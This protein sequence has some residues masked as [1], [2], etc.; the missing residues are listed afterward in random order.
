[1]AM[2]RIGVRRMTMS[3]VGELAG[4]S[5]GT[6][7]RYFPTKEDLLGVVAQYEQQRFADGLRNAVEGAAGGGMQLEEVAEFIVSY[8]R[9]HPAVA[10]LVETEPA[11]SITF[12]RR[13]LPLFLAQTEELIGPALSNAVAVKEGRLTVPQLSEVLLRLVVSVFLVGG[14]TRSDT[15]GVLERVLSNFV[16]LVSASLD[17]I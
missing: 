10:M 3:D 13:E 9:E 2:G 7:Y 14:E 15:L 4:L 16:K 11:F 8:M 12:L 5:R 17:E 6:V 1:M